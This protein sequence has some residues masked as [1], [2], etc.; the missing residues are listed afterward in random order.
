MGE[1]RMDQPDRGEV[2]KVHLSRLHL[3]GVREVNPEDIT[4][5]TQDNADLRA[6]VA[7]LATEDPIMRFRLCWRVSRRSDGRWVASLQGTGN[8][9]TPLAKAFRTT[10]LDR[11]TDLIERIMGAADGR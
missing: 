7:A 6:I 3:E 11:L 9:G 2:R 10:G 1:D 5:L 8:P 4:R